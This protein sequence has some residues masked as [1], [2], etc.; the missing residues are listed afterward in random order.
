M[1]QRNKKG[2]MQDMNGRIWNRG[3]IVGAAVAGSAGFLRA[4][5]ASAGE[6]PGSG[7]RAEQIQ[8]IADLERQLNEIKSL[9]AQTSWLN[10]ARREEVSALAR[11]AAA[12]SARRTSLLEDGATG[13]YMGAGKGFMLQ[14]ADGGFSMRIGVNTQFRWIWDNRDSGG[15]ANF[16]ENSAGFE[17]RRAK[18]NLKGALFDK[19]LKYFILLPF[20]RSSGALSVDD[21]YFDWAADD[22]WTI[23]WGQFKPTFN[24]EELVSDTQQLAIE[25]SFVNA[26]VSLDRSQ[27]V[28]LA[29]ANEGFKFTAGF[30]DG[31]AAA[32]NALAV[33]NANTPFTADGTEWAFTARAEGALAGKIDQFN[34]YTTWSDD[35]EF[36][37][38]LGGAIH[39]QNG[40]YGTLASE[41]ETFQWTVDLAAEWAGG[42]NAA[43][44]VIGRTIDING[45]SSFD[46]IGFVAQA[47]W[48][49]EDKWE[50]FVRYEWWDWDGAFTDELS[51]LTAGLNFYC[52]GHKH[53][54][55]FSADVVYGLNAIPL[56][57]AGG[58]LQADSAGEDGQVAL[59]T[60]V[61]VLF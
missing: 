29:Y 34:D 46:Q 14:S 61:Q 37:M 7:D 45:G 18:L 38:L 30:N 31:Y 54:M 52:G 11:E 13:G 1:L 26:I 35:E 6:A 8:R 33:R 51:I 12:D 23:R 55:K 2:W 4:A 42:L 9:R 27:G 56:S 22:H 50:P 17:F 32:A 25:R 24:H 39:W 43:G 20:S 59:R 49:I 57:Y 58:G 44:S 19:R 10:P 47:G 3:V 48:N 41:A 28:A 5:C 40:E 36:G 15:A 21:A 60:Q 16:D 53:D